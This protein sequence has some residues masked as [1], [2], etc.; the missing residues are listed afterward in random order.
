MKKLFYHFALLALCSIVHAQRVD[1][2]RQY[3]NYAYRNLPNV[4]LDKSFQ[5]Y[6]VTV[7]KTVTLELFS[8]EAANNKINIE[9]RKKVSGRG[10]FQVN[11]SMGDLLIESSKVENRVVVSKDK[12]GKETGRTY[13]YWAEVIY[14]FEAGARIDDFNGN[15]LKSYNLVSRDS[16]KTFKTSE[17]GKSS[18]A[19]DYYNN[20]RYEIK[21]NLIAEQIDQAMSSLNT[22]L[23]YDFGYLSLLSADKFW[24]L[25]SK[26]HEEFTAYGEAIASAKTAIETIT[27]NAI[28]A[29]INDKL[30][31]SIDYFNG[32]LTKYT[33][34]EDKGQKKLRYGAYFN[35]AFIYYSIENF[36]KAIE[37]ANLLVMNDYDGKDG[38]RLVKEINDIKTTLQK[39][40]MTTR[41]FHPD[42]DNALAPQ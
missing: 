14:S 27:A 39:N 2:D 19:S 10:H 33:D 17:Y 24:T 30:K 15:K 25:G 11:I 32:L 13:Y 20:N 28:P 22:S 31:P 6:S 41:H 26:K 16:K 7:D 1:L 37:N 42:C 4:V 12:D 5:T 29:D 35:L 21:A 38:E 18:D 9:G 23:N 36:D 40:S 8:N 3:Y 34:P